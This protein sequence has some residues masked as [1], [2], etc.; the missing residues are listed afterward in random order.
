M[1]PWTAVRARMHTCFSRA[2]LVMA[3]VAMASIFAAYAVVACVVVAYIAVV[4]VV[5][6]CV[7]MA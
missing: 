2:D 3:C 6:T 5:M 1:T 4:Y 7:F